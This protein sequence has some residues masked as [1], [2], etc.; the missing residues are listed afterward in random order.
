MRSLFVALI[1]LG[2]A[3]I[4]PQVLDSTAGNATVWHWSIQ[5]LG[6]TWHPGG[7]GNHELYP[8]KFDK[9]G[10]LVPEVGAAVK[11]D[12][13]L[14]DSFF[15][16]LASAA[17]KDCAF[18]TAGCVQMGPRYQ[19]VWGRNTLN[20]GIGPIFSFRRDWHRFKE[21]TNDDFYGNRVAHGWQYRFFPTAIELEYLR[22]INDTTEFQWSVVP[23][24]PLVVTSMFGFRFKL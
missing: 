21:F 4:T 17:Y 7:G 12:Y 15:L 5:Y 18:V 11:L 23:G 10:Y 9:K 6:L 24:A 13:R 19:Y 1:A 16:R 14:N 20:A 8:L 3:C 2:P 22:R